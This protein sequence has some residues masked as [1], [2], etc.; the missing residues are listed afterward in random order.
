LVNKKGV[1]FHQNNARPHVSKKTKNFLNILNWDLLEHPPYSPDIAASDFYL[2]RYLQN[3]LC[4]AIF[5]GKD[6]TISE[7]DNYLYSRTPD[8][9]KKAFD[10]LVERWQEVLDSN[11]EYILD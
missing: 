1:I 10:K 5:S 3:F 6:E 7:V 11:G 4:G 8:F 2:F 9:F